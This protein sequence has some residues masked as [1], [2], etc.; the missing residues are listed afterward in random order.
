MNED[1]RIRFP[2][3]IRLFFEDGICQYIEATEDG[4]I[5][6]R[7]AGIDWALDKYEASKE[8][9][10]RVMEIRAEGYNITRFQPDGTQYV[11]NFG[12][13]CCKVCGEKL[14]EVSSPDWTHCSVVFHVC[15]CQEKRR[16]ELEAEKDRAAQAAKVEEARKDCFQSDTLRSTTFQADSR[17]NPRISDAMRRYA[18]GFDEKFRPDAKGLLLYGPVGTGKTFYA[19]CIANALID[20]GHKVK[21]TSFSRIVNAVMERFEGRQQIIDSLGTYDLVVID[22]LGTERST[23]TVADYVFQAVDCL[24]QWNVPMI[25]TTNLSMREMQNP[26]TYAQ[27]RIYDRI[28]ERCFPVE[29]KGENIRRTSIIDGYG[30]TKEALGL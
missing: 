27:G 6:E 7:R 3:N 28:L 26:Q 29:F 24:Y 22:D 19:A 23:E 13:V 16:R 1:Y 12:N 18:Q 2:H 20:G 15:G 21:F 30:A 8:F 14:L 17:G 9:R 10:D 11:D 4:G 5:K 25:Y